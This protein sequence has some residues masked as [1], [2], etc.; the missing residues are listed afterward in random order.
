MSDHLTLQSDPAWVKF[1][2]M[3]TNDDLKKFLDPDLDPRKAT[4]PQ[5]RKVM[6]H[7]EI[8]AKY[9]RSNALKEDLVEN[10]T[11]RL[12]PIIRPMLGEPKSTNAIM[13]DTQDIPKLDLDSNLTTKRKLRCELAKHVP[14]L[15]T[16]SEMSRPELLR[17]Y[18]NSI[19]LEQPD[20]PTQGLTMSPS[21][22]KSTDTRYTAD[23]PVWTHAELL[24]KRRDDIRF[25]L[26]VHKPHIFIPTKCITLTI[27]QRIYEKFVLNMEVNTDVIIEGVHYYLRGQ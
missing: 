13:I 25:A 18:Q 3:S 9:R 10:Y 15:E 21:T 6:A 26:Q 24:E 5:L 20:Q 1:Q 12:L 17:L 16:N 23:P 2:S 7:F 14:T 4:C 22:S 27:C 11:K 19:L 8:E